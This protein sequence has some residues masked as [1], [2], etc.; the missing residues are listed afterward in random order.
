MSDKVAAVAESEGEVAIVKIYN[1]GKGDKKY[2]TYIGP[3]AGTE[4]LFD[5]ATDEYMGVYN[6]IT[7]KLDTTVPDLTLDDEGE[8]AVV[9]IYN[10]GKG[11][12][13]YD[14]FN[15]PKAGTEYL[16]D[17]ATD[18]Y[19]GLYTP[20]TKKLDTTVED[21]SL[22]DKHT[23]PPPKEI[24]KS[25]HID[26][27]VNDWLLYI[28]DGK[29][30]NASSSKSI[31][32]IT[33]NHS[34]TKGFL[35]TAKTGDRLWFV[36]SKTNGKI[37]A[38]ATFT[39]TNK[40]ILGPLIQLTLTNEELGWDKTDDNWDTEVHY[41]DLYNLTQCNLKSEIKGAA[42]IRRYNNK[43]KVD[44]PTEYPYIVRY[45]KISKHM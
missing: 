38:V 18:K 14:T 23:T 10:L 2:D 36:K 33:S 35:S 45:S 28:G 30:F 42:G 6:P 5:C 19:V 20:S 17:N 9:K 24:Q 39:S 16:F 34:F 13:K 27:K 8:V 31:W 21:P 41:K 44:L 3:K 43:C 1:L 29:N 12:K 11:A 22:E 4:Y 40:R 15:G 26:T 7:K 25:I 32:G 37:I